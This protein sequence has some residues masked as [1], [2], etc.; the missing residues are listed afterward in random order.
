MNIVVESAASEAS[1]LAHV[2]AHSHGQGWHERGCGPR[3]V[4]L[5]RSQGRADQVA[6]FGLQVD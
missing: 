2:R 4:Q 5:R 1:I 6:D 3:G